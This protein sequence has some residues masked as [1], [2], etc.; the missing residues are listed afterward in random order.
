MFL[1]FLF[2]QVANRCVNQ[3]DEVC[4]EIEK[5]I[6]HTIQ[7]TLNSLERDCEAIASKIKK[8]LEKDRETVSNNF[9]SR[10]KG[11]LFC[12][13]AVFLPVLLSITYLAS[14]RTFEEFLVSALG[15]SSAQN[16]YVYLVCSS[17]PSI[18][19]IPIN[20]KF[21]LIFLLVDFRTPWRIC[22]LPYLRRIIS[23]Y[24]E[25][26][27]RWPCSCC[28]WPNLLWSNYPLFFASCLCVIE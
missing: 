6:K 10:A 24:G 18:T 19:L 16:V 11:S 23:T 14:L 12:C 20:I 21:R 17:L 27:L 5:T 9:R 22:V 25:C 13:I 15:R 8:K 1:C 4:K 26:W 28:C 2:V 7:N 3:I